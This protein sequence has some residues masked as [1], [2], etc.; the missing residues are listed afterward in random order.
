MVQQ[1]PDEGAQWGGGDYYPYSAGLD[2]GNSITA[3]LWAWPFSPILAH[4]WLLSA[5]LLTL[6]PSALQPLRDKVLGTPPW[7]LWG[8]DAIPAHPEYGL[9]LDFWSMRL[10]TDFPSNTTF[11]AEV[12]LIL[13]L[14]EAALILA[15]TRLTGIIFNYSRKRSRAIRTWQVSSVIILATFD[16]IHFLL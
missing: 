11:L 2:G 8:I 6:G 15:G 9:G 4:T 1:L 12:F 14:L 7:R 3:T 16:V 5:D 13:L 10:W